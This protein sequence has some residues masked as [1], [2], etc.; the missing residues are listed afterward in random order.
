LP[1]QMFGFLV[2]ATIVLATGFGAIGPAL[3]GF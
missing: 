3:P 1:M 2:L